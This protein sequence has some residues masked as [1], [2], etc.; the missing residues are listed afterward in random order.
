MR[1]CRLG[2]PVQDHTVGGG[3]ASGERLDKRGLIDSYAIQEHIETA[4]QP[5]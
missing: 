4:E 1:K 2:I 3:K 5:D